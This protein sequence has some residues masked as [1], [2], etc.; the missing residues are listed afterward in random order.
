MGN[1]QVGEAKKNEGS[2]FQ[3]DDCDLILQ[4]ENSS[5]TK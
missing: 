4:L 5:D 1:K 3:K 2:G